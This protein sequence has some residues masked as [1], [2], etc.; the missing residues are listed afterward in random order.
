[1]NAEQLVAMGGTLWDKSGYARVYF[2][3]DIVKGVAFKVSYDM[4]GKRVRSATLIGLP[5]SNGRAAWIETTF[6]DNKFKLYYDLNDKRWQYAYPSCGVQCER[7]LLLCINT[8]ISKVEKDGV[9][10]V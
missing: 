9:W 7:D 8:F 6:K 5:I 2:D 3:A 4:T 1:M 10:C